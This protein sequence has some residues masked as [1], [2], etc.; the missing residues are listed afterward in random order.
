MKRCPTKC[1][2]D[3]ECTQFASA[4]CVVNRCT[5]ELEWKTA[6][7]MTIKCDERKHPFFFMFRHFQAKPVSLPGF[8]IDLQWKFSKDGGHSPYI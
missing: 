5:C 3:K 6:S 1:P 7:G 4:Q 8:H 2:E